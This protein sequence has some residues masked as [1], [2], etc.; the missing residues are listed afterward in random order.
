MTSP[1]TETPAGVDP[2]FTAPERPALV[3]QNIPEP[4][5]VAS[6]LADRHR[7][8]LFVA[9]GYR[10]FR[11]ATARTWDQVAD[12]SQ[13]TRADGTADPSFGQRSNEDARRAWLEHYQWLHT[14]GPTLLLL[15]DGGL[16]DGTVE[17]D[18]RAA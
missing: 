7:L 12:P 1:S 6:L 2:A 15:L 8:T 14:Y 10:L 18:A 9:H 13:A 11:R 16:L 5:E 17:K 3:T 4:G